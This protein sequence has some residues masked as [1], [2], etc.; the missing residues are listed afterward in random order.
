MSALT[1]SNNVGEVRWLIE[2]FLK[3]ALFIRVGGTDLFGGTIHLGLTVTLLGWQEVQR[4]A[5]VNSSSSLGFV[6]MSFRPEFDDLYTQGIAP[7]IA[8]AG[9]EPLRVDRK[10]HN[11]RIDDEIIV[12]IKRSRFLVADFSV[13]RGGIYFEAGYALGLGIP[14]VWVVQQDRLDSV[15]F[16]NRQ[17]NFVRWN[18]G[19]WAQLKRALKLRIEA[20]IG[21][22]PREVREEEYGSDGLC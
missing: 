11:N 10:E 22:G 16:D 3:T 13:D 8:A 5:E 1:S 18:T 15:H 20:T 4:L 9:F 14:V 19:E 6:A 17:Y 2:D 21:R 7:G 12:S